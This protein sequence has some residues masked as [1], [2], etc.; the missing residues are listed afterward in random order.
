MATIRQLS[1]R[2]CD[3]A[4]FTLTEL[5]VVILLIGVLAALALPVFLDQQQKGD[6]AVAKSN[7][8]N[9]VSQVEA[10]HVPPEDYTKCDGAGADDELPADLGLA[11]G[12]GPGEV[13]VSGAETSWFEVTAVSESESEGANHVFKIR[14]SVDGTQTRSCTAG[15]SNSEGACRSGSW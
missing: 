8:R 4:G 10:C 7:A 6:D 12:G 2:A 3:E 5:L 9:L 15:P 13:R 1:A 11:L 14:K